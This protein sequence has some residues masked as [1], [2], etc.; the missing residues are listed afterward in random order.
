ATGLEGELEYSVELFDE[1][2]AALIVDDLRT[3]LTDAAES[4]DARLADLLGR[5]KFG[6]RA[7]ITAS[8][9]GA[10]TA[11]E[12]CGRVGGEGQRVLPHD[13]LQGELLAIWED[14][15]A[16]SPIGIHDDFFQL[17]GHSLLALALL[18]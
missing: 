16:V 8:V 5:T 18:D 1:A 2:S 17:G 6:E 12:R 14:V 11:L 15:L 10:G 3:L 4:P 9:S 13:S 7:G